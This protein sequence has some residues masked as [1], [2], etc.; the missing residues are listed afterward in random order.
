MNEIS[1]VEDAAVFSRDHNCQ[2]SSRTGETVYGAHLLMREAPSV[3][4]IQT[5]DCTCESPDEISVTEDT[6]DM[7]PDTTVNAVRLKFQT[8]H[9][10]YIH[11]CSSSISQSLAFNWSHTS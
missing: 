10:G 3:S 7:M 2:L 5:I 4:S 1:A 6:D 8:P 11:F 9:Y